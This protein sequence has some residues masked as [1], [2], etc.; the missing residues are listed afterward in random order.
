M[1]WLVTWLIVKLI[2]VGAVPDLN[3]PQAF[4]KV[5]LQMMFDKTFTFGSTSVISK[6]FKKYPVYF[7]KKLQHIQAYFNV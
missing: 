5:S 6:N 2:E 4:K 7:K 1:S 3:E